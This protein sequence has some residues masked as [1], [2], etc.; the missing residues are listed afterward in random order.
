MGCV[1]LSDNLY[2]NLKDWL[3][4]S[5]D[6]TEIYK[7][8]CEQDDF[9][10]LIQ[11]IKKVLSEEKYI[12]LKNTPLRTKKHLEVFIKF[13]GIFYGNIEHTGIKIECNYTGCATSKLILHND[14][15]VDL[16]SQPT[17]GFIQVIK[18]DPLFEVKNGIVVIR[19]LIRKLRYEDPKLLELLLTI[20]VP[21]LSAG[22]NYETEN[23]DFIETN[24][25]IL[26]KEDGQYKV[27]FDYN[28]IMFYYQH[29]RI[30]QTHQEGEMIY[31][32][33]KHCEAIKKEFF[34]NEGDI[35]IHD[36]KSTLHDRS[37]C[38]IGID[39]DKKV[40]SREI[41]VSFAL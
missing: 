21:M 13:F 30:K 11:S 25:P 2:A 40:F 23:K 16:K 7:R 20:E 31:N 3:E 5:N 9:I 17:L 29:K 35:F 10:F 36:N 1:I 14:D 28:R 4:L 18:I 32:F 37:S 39:T 33:I 38:C 27:R 34:L 8:L 24:A 22:V 26:Y 12:V 6:T 15:A 41:F 19:E